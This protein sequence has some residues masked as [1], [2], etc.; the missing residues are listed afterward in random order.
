LYK[1][2]W[3]YAFSLTRVAP[4]IFDGVSAADL[5]NETMLAFLKSPDAMGWQPGKGELPVFLCGVLRHKFL[6]H[7]KRHRRIAGSVDDGAF[8]AA[9]EARPAPG[10]G[11]LGQLAAKQWT[12]SLIRRLSPHREL[13]EVVAAVAATDGSHN[14]NQQIAEELGTTPSDVANR[15]KR[16]LRILFGGSK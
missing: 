1:R 10:S 4:D 5:V 15:K 13:Q 11:L 7:L 2:L 12:A 14:S 6:D 16:I 9:L 8:R 3:V